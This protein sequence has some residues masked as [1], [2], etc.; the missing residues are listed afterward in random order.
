MLNIKVDYDGRLDDMDVRIWAA[1]VAKVTNLTQQ[2][3]EQVLENLSGKILQ[4]KS[5]QLLGSI[6]QTVDAASDTVT[7]VVGP[8]PSTPKAAALEL[9]GNRSY[10][11]LPTKGTVLKFYWDK[12]GSTVFF[13]SV[14]HP[15]SKEYAYLRT[16][17]E[18][19]SGIAPEEVR[20]A[21][22]SVIDGR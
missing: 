7:G 12:M 11:I 21:M 22:Q 2:M 10:T 13:P 14:N 4:V 16:V 5:G 3:Y 1:V 18:E 9:G 20:L 8:E 17:M 19:M 15:P 6:R